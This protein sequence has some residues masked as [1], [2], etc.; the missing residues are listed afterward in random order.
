MRLLAALLQSAAVTEVSL[1]AAYPFNGFCL[2]E[3]V[4]QFG[5]I[6]LRDALFSQEAAVLADAFD[7][8]DS[9]GM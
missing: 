3:V 7:A 6:C 9:A 1:I 4:E 2:C 5:K 8:A